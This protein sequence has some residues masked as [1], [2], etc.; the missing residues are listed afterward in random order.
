MAWCPKCG[1]AHLTNQIHRCRPSNADAIIQDLY[2]S[3]INFSIV[4]FWDAGFQV[5]LGDDINGFGAK[6]NAE[7]FAC[8]VEWLKVRA[9]EKYP[10]SDFAQKH[11]S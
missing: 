1:G 4:T 2:D 9:I 6:G 5:R 3:E 7:D 11:R 8:A 10:E